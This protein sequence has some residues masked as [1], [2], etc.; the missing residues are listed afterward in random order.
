MITQPPDPGSSSASSAERRI[1]PYRV[2]GYLGAG[3]AGEVLL[4][5]DDRLGRQVAIK[6]IR[7]DLATSERERERFL[8]EARAVARLSHP[9][10][11][12]LHEVVEEPAGD[13]L[14]MEYVEGET[15]AARLG[16]GP[17]CLP[18]ILRLAME[19]AEA[20]GE[21]HGKGIIHRDLKAENVMVTAHGHAKILDFGVAKLIR[22]TP[23][24]GPTLTG[25]GAVVGTCRSMSPEQAGGREVDARTDLFAF[26]VLLYEMVTGTSPFIGVDALRTLYNVVHHRPPPVRTLRPET[27]AALSMLIDRLIEKDPERRPSDA[28]AVSRELSRISSRQSAWQA[29]TLDADDAFGA[30]A[31]GAIGALADA[32]EAPATGHHRPTRR[33]ILAA[34]LLLGV[35]AGSGYLLLPR[36]EPLR[37]AVLPPEIATGDDAG[38][39]LVSAAVLDGA[40]TTLILLERVSPVDPRELESLAGTPAEIARAVAADEVLSTEIE[41]ESGQAWILLRRIA[42]PDGETLWTERSE[43]PRTPRDARSVADRVAGLLRQAYPQHPLPEEAPRHAVRDQDYAAFLG[44]KLRFE[45]GN[46]SRKTELEELERILAGSPEFI[47]GWLLAASAATTL[48]TDTRDPAY[49]RRAARLLEPAREL[50][51]ADPRLLD[52]DFRLALE[53]GELERAERLLQELARRDPND[54]RVP[55]SRAQLAQER[56]DLATAVVAMR[57]VIERRPSWRYLYQI[58]RWEMRGG[59]VDSARGHLT[60]LLRR[61]P[62]NTHGLGQLVRL[63]LYFG[64]L[65]RAEELALKL[66]GIKRHRNYF[67]NLGLAQF[68]QGRFREAKVSYR[69]ALELAPDH[70]VPLLNLADAENALGNREA[71]SALYRKALD[72]LR[73]KEA[74]AALGATDRLNRAQCLAQLGEASQ[75]VEITVDVL[76]Q[77]GDEPAVAH[78]AAL[79]YTLVGETTSAVVQAR[80]ALA[81]NF[82][83]RWFE[84]P[85]FRALHEDPEFRELFDSTAAGRR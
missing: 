81:K 7:R 55:Y 34:V 13:A 45:T 77:H 2:A 20:L 33:A 6:R 15:V 58:A 50:A 8:R 11:V 31:T 51:P 56:G 18:E 37:V 83:R 26:G 59:D 80:H 36:P 84:I 60:E 43:V 5:D 24:D 75:A 28:A 17:L 47:D 32:G 85:D 12:Q 68:L 22:R 79:V 54:L 82:E 64:N 29:T 46:A 35:L 70:V 19:I 76:R 49:L 73:R 66:T 42:G 74:S 14:V 71:A 65:A 48:F 52:Q 3:G 27:P 30:A 67:T 1:G 9:A 10:I 23:A 4:A 41:A 72:R 40:L 78:Q 21:A 44:V 62:N 69:Q 53:G 16:D 63:E 39:E 25:D 61:A 38:L 57:S